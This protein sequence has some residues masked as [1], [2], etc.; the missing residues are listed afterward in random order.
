MAFEGNREKN[1]EVI[2]GPRIGVGTP[3]LGNV[4]RNP[5]DDDTSTVFESE[6]GHDIKY[7]S[8]TWKKTAALLFCEYIW[9]YS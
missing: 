2:R 8:L 6:E 1:V 7:K 5:S 4:E 3:K 9:Y